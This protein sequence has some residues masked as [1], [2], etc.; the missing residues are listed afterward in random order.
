VKQSVFVVRD[1]VQDLIESVCERLRL[2]VGRGCCVC[3]FAEQAARVSEIF[4]G[5]GHGVDSLVGVEGRR[6]QVLV[7]VL[8]IG[9]YS[10]SL[11]DE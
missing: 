1:F 8:G 4:A 9:G 7:A 5:Y 11:S 2:V 3:E 6:R 10:V